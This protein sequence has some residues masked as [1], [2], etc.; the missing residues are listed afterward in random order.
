MESL[1]QTKQWVIYEL[2]H[3][4]FPATLCV[5]I[6][7]TSEM[8]NLCSRETTALPKVMQEACKVSAG[9]PASVHHPHGIVIM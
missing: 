9:L 2:Y 8:S 7:L 3:L 1:S 5:G 4:I 6:I